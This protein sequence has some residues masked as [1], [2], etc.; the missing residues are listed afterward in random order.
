MKKFFIIILFLYSFLFIIHPAF[1]HILQVDNSIGAILHVDPED[2]PIAGQ[3]S[4]FFLE[5]KDKTNR[6]QSTNCYCRINILQRGNIIYSN[7]L[8]QQ[9]L[10]KNTDTAYDSFTFPSKDVYQLKIT[11][12]P[13][14]KPAFQSFTLT[15]DIRVARIADTS[16]QNFSWFS[17]YLLYILIG[18]IM[19][20]FGFI[21]VIKK[22]V[23]KGG[24]KKD[25]KKNNRDM[26]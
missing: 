19:I 15:Y 16:P 24:E 18:I 21:I 20:I 1:A 5:F 25:D 14:T 13:K 4:T 8:F 23:M 3:P 2:D 17:T 26:Y 22:H 7:A 9:S 6:F 11:G 10:D 12:K